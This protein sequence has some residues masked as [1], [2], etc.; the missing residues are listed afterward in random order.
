MGVLAGSAP[1][2]CGTGIT[3]SMLH[4]A[5]ARPKRPRRLMQPAG[6]AAGIGIVS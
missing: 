6:G 4:H 3:P 1:G 2:R 5:G